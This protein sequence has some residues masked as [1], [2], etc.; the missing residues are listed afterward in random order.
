[1]LCTRSGQNSSGVF[2]VLSK[3]DEEN[4][5]LLSIIRR[6]VDERNSLVARLND[7]PALAS[8]DEHLGRRLKHLE[9]T[10]R[11]WYSWQENRKDLI[12]T[13]NLL[14]DEDP[15]IRDLAAEDYQSLLKD[16]T[17]TLEDA[18]P[19][20]LVLPSKTNTLSALLEIKPG[21]GGSESSLFLQDLLRMYTRYASLRDWPSKIVA[22]EDR[23]GGGMKNA[24]LEIVGEGAYDCL[25]WESGV[26]RVQR[27]PATESSGRVHTSTV[28]VIVL[29]LTDEGNQQPDLDNLF[30]EKDVRIE[31]MRARGAGG[32][33]V[34][35]T[36][37]AVR[38]THIPTGITVSMQDERT[39]AFQVLR[40]RLL[41]RKI[42]SDTKERRD[43][44]RQLVKSADRSEKIRTYQYVQ[45]RVTDHRIGLTV[46]GIA[47]VLD[48]NG[49]QQFLDA[50]HTNHHHALIEDALDGIEE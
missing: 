25:R 16:Y 32:Q 45:D 35:K 48:G 23:D 46:K 19:S 10:Y 47:P 8:S 17:N 27:V 43:T 1:M 3:L 18:F 12:D 2:S 37:S 41:D 50:L 11:T 28:Q 6:R 34:N 7:D 49:L 5:R 42:Q 38:L 30:D 36:E 20:L 21:V 40:A 9:D 29:P 14:E 39:R 26:H 44:R 24:I 33:H 31:V 22:K 15:D 4:Q 13:A